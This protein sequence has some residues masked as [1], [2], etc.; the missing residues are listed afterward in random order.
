MKWRYLNTKSSSAAFN[1]SAD[2]FLFEQYKIDRQPI[3]RIYRW[4]NPCISLGRNQ[5]ADRALNTTNCKLDNI[6]IV[7]RPTG[8]QAIFH[9]T[10]ELS[11]SLI[12]SLEDIGASA[13]V[14]D[15]YDKI[16]SI[17]ITCYRS[18]S[19]D[20]GFAKEIKANK[21]TDLGHENHLCFAQWESDDIIIAN[22]KIGGN[23]QRRARDIVLQHGSIPLEFRFELAR[24]YINSIPDDIEKRTVA[25]NDLLLEP[26]SLDQ[27]EKKFVDTIKEKF[28]LEISQLSENEEKEIKRRMYETRVA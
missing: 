18:L 25:L 20:A 14:R 10:N 4:A 3:L 13:K 15:S 22:K 12:A 16:C 27:F 21:C 9:L 5:D 1:M 6:E 7:K 24:R 8:G 26:L 11:Y 17:L 28:D 2:E 19:L 23:A